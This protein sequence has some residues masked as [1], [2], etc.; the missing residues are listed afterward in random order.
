M[1]PSQY[2]LA[3]TFVTAAIALL[4]AVVSWRRRQRRWAQYLTCFAAGEVLQ[5]I[6]WWLP[7]SPEWLFYLGCTLVLAGSAIYLTGVRSLFDWRRHDP[8][9]SR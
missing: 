7:G 4:L 3:I 8:S 2:T 6:H 1:S 9:A 5:W